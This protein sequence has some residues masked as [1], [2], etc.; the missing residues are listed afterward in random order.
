MLLQDLEAAKL[1]Y[2]DEDGRVFDFH[3]LRHQFIS[4]LAAA[5]VHPKVAQ[6]LARHSSI[7]RTMNCYTHV[8]LADVSDALASLPD[9]TTQK[10]RG[11]ALRATGTDD[12]PAKRADKK[13]R[14]TPVKTTLK[15]SGGGKMGKI[16]R[17]PQKWPEANGEQE[18]NEAEGRGFEPPTPFGAP[19]FESGCWPIRLPSRV[20]K[21]LTASGMA[22]ND[23][24]VRDAG[25]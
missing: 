4:S 2:E 14:S 5:G 7:D 22:G 23:G 1:P 16:A 21:S 15:L 12:P 19:D 18:V 20:L 8:A 13:V 11:E 6:Q 24:S 9:P 3:A 10:E 25:A 17:A